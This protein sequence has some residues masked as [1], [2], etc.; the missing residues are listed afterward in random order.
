MANLI[1]ILEH[2]SK[3]NRAIRSLYRLDSFL[4]DNR[5]PDIIISLER[6]ILKSALL[7]LNNEQIKELSLSW[8]EQIENISLNDEKISIID[9][10]D[11]DVYLKNLN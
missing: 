6:E 11:F 10:S 1:E 9:N 4:K 8:R 3:I 2:N 7:E 5:Y